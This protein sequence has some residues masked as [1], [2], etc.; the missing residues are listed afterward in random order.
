[1]LEDFVEAN[2]VP[3]EFIKR[4]LSVNV[5]R[6][7]L[8]VPVEENNTP[9]LCIFMAGKRLSLERAEEAAGFKLRAVGEKE[10]FR[11]TGYEQGFLPPVSIYGVRVLVD[12]GVLEKR[13]VNA[14]VGEALTLRIE[15]TAIL[16][17]NEDAVACSVVE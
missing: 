5:V 7:V 9:V 6:C 14:I 17:F 1:M 15:S 16:E 13:F 12:R 11:I 4:E 2:S 10:A 8:L 3:A